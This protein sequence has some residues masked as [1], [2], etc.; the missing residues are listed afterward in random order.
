MSQNSYNQIITHIFAAH[1]RKGLKA[2]DFKREEIAQAAGS[3]GVKCPKNLGDVVYTFRY[4][5][6][7]PEDIIKQAPAGREWIIRPSGPARYRFALVRE[8]QLIPNANLARIKV[9]DATPGIISKYALSDEQALLAKLRYNR[10]IDVFTGVACYSLQNHLRTAV[11]DIGQ[12]ETDEVYVGI[13]RQGAHYAIP[14]QAKG[15]R[16]RLSRV[17]IEQDIALC[18]A[19]FKELVCRP[20]GAQFIADDMIALFEFEQDG[21]EIRIRSERH[22]LLVPPEEVTSEDLRHYRVPVE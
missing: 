2:F 8:W 22:Y 12:I 4:R 10:L 14:V 3:L 5:R 15:G 21:D 1:H 19:R 9:P 13:D 18:R 11:E 16:D 17:Q 20:I 7:L 6:A